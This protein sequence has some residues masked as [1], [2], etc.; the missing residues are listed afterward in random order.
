[1]ECDWS[2]V[3]RLLIGSI[4]SATLKV[5]SYQGVP[6]YVTFLHV[7]ISGGMLP[8]YTFLRSGSLA[9]I[10]RAQALRCERWT[11]SRTMPSRA[12]TLF[13]FKDHAKW[14]VLHGGVSLF[15]A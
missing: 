9:S 2:V 15:W 14:N 1:M 3:C 13:T 4:K 10:Y 7:P 12:G 11:Y 6:I 5:C 8:F